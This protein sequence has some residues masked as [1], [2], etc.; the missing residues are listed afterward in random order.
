[1]C[2]PLSC[3][4]MVSPLT[5]TTQYL[6]SSAMDLRLSVWKTLKFK[7]LSSTRWHSDL[8]SV[9]PFPL[10][11]GSFRKIEKGTAAASQDL[12]THTPLLQNQLA[13]MAEGC[14]VF[15]EQESPHQIGG[16][17]NYKRVV[18]TYENNQSISW[19]L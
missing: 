11:C 10:H 17:I 2:W 1:M 19:H 12:R 4:T 15:L 9:S 18:H 5:P 7:N 13:L 3:N 6:L 16:I 8:I 14:N